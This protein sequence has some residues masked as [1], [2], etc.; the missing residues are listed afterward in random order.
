VKEKLRHYVRM[1]YPIE[2][3]PDEGGFLA[4]IPDLPGCISSGQTPEEALQGL[5]EAKEL[6]VEGRLEAGLTIPEP[7]V[8]SDYSGKFVLRIPR[9]LHRDLDAAARHD[10]VSLNQYI[11]KLLSERLQLA[12]VQ[13]SLDRLLDTSAGRR[14]AAVDFAQ[15]FETWIAEK[16]KAHRGSWDRILSTMLGESG[17]RS[18]PAEED[19]S[20]LLGETLYKVDVKNRPA[21][22]E[23][24]RDLEDLPMP[25]A[26][27][28]AF[29]I[30]RPVW[31][32][33]NLVPQRRK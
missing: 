7:T 29:S 1:P 6:W 3:V 31:E 23:I 5:E 2:L 17:V 9:S 16:A 21:S 13:A 24:I 22:R 18:R 8:P 28:Q 30:K 20:L 27:K 25:P 4:S 32:L 15:Q 33:P 11:V 26:G 14:R 19:I 10:G 12:R